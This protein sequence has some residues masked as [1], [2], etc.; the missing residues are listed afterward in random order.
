MAKEDIGQKCADERA[1][2]IDS[3]Y[4]ERDSQLCRAWGDKPPVEHSDRDLRQHKA[5]VE[6]EERCI[7]NLEPCDGGIRAI[8]AR[9][10]I[11]FEYRILQGHTDDP[12]YAAEPA[13]ESDVVGRDRPA[14]LETYPCKEAQTDHDQRE[15]NKHG[16]DA[17]AGGDLHWLDGHDERPLAPVEF[18]FLSLS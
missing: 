2:S 5:K 13:C 18:S 17:I 6:E 1:T 8:G 16:H 7:D 11:L 14:V 12:T 4:P 10:A 9:V 3:A 15:R